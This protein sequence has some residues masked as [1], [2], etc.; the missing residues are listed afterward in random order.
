MRKPARRTPL[1]RVSRVKYRAIGRKVRLRRF[2]ATLETCD[3]GF[4]SFDR[5]A[6]P[7]LNEIRGKVG[8]AFQR[9]VQR[10][11]G[12]GFRRYMEPVVAMP[13]PVAR[14]VG[15]VFELL[16]GLTE[17]RFGVRRCIE[18]DYGG[19]TVFH[20]SSHLVVHLFNKLGVGRL[21]LAV[22]LCHVGF[23]P[24]GRASGH[25]P[26]TFVKPALTTTRLLS[27][28]PSYLMHSRPLSTAFL[29]NRRR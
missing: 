3:A 24:G 4:D 15:T 6:D 7:L 14:G 12:F 19:S 17:R 20:D 21:S 23:L 1:R 28:T 27:L 26:C 8:F 25:P 5:P 11:F 9:L 10:A 18:L 29:S 2:L 16:D 22:V 13:T